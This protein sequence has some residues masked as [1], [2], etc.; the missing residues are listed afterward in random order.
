MRS[1]FAAFLLALLCL[2]FAYVAVRP[3]SSFPTPISS[4]MTDLEHPAVLPA[5][6]ETCQQ[7]SSWDRAS[8]Y[9][10]ATGKYVNWDANGDGGGFI[11]AGG[12]PGGHGRDG[13]PGLHLADLVG[14]GPARAREDLSRRQ[15]RAGRRSAVRR[16][17]HRRHGA[18]QL[19]AV[20]YDLAE[21][22]CRGQNL[23]FPIPYQKSCKIVAEK[24]WGAYYQFV[25][26]TFPQG[27]KLP[28]F[29]RSWPPQNAERLAASERLP[30]ATAGQRS[31]RPRARRGADHRRTVASP[32]ARRPSVA[33][34]DGPA[35]DHGDPRQDDL[36]ATAR[37]RWPPCGELVPADHLRRPGE[38]G[39]LVPAGRFLRHGPRLEPLHSLVTGMTDEGCY[40]YWY[41]PFGKSAV[42]ELVNDDDRSPR[43]RATTIVHA[44]LG[45]AFD[46]LGHFHCKWHR[47]T[48]RCPKTAGPTGRC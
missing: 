23:Y 47:D 26:T 2:P 15:R 46:G 34:L 32:P 36:R 42:V 8:K 28:T 43:R 22:G 25:Y 20:S 27:T 1:R 35:R 14:P 48:I 37:T 10:A 41:M 4:R 39:R 31:R 13:R 29:S 45:R 44:P 16:L 9:D 33:E 38:A 5:P 24:G 40:A 30:P 6:G 7:W 17:F 3:R 11:R 12:R 19:P 21:K 18:V